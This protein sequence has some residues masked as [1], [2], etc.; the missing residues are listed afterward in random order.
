MS[1]FIEYLRVYVTMI[2][3]II[4]MHD[5]GIVYSSS[6]NKISQSSDSGV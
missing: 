4:N 6:S 3:N 1:L 5:N 2:Y